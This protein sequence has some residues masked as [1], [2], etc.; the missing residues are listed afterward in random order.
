MLCL[1][2]SP[3]SMLIGP[4]FRFHHIRRTHCVNALLAPEPMFNAHWSARTS[5]MS[6]RSCGAED[7]RS[8][9]AAAGG[10]P[11]HRGGGHG[12][13]SSAW[14]LQCACCGP[15]RLGK[16]RASTNAAW[17]R[18]K[19][20]PPST[21][22]NVNPALSAITVTQLQALCRPSPPLR[23]RPC[24]S[25]APGRTDSQI[26]QPSGHSRC[27]TLPACPA[28]CPPYLCLCC[29]LCARCPCERCITAPSAT[30]CERR[31]GRALLP[32]QGCR[33]C[34]RLPR[35]NLPV[36]PFRSSCRPLHVHTLHALP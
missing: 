17:A 3:C 34:H 21:H 19:A 33:C 9:A 10:R 15:T 16:P 4:H 14:R 35:S 23:A 29:G 36:G 32:P 5:I 18:S 13:C 24:V 31:Q 1:H 7:R 25:A 30:R 27:G 26:Q 28:S 8:V 11:S 2:L 20:S 22:Y 12:D 6:R